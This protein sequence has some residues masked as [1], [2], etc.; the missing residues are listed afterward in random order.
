MSDLKQFLLDA[1][2]EYGI[3]L[4]DETAEKFLIYKDMLSDWNRRINLTAITDDEGIIIKH[5]IDSLLCWNSGVMHNNCRLIDIGT[6]AGFPG[7]ALKLAFPW[8]K[9]W[10]LDSVRKKLLFLEDVIKTLSLSDV[11][12]I[13]GRAE[14]YGKKASF[15]ES[16]DVVTARAVAALPVLAEYCL[17]FAKIGGHVLCMKGPEVQQELS[18]SEKAV[19]LLGGE[20]KDVLHLSLPASSGD[21]HIV[22]LNK[23]KPT[24]AAYPRKP[25]VPAKKP[26]I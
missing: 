1:A 4:D 12:L 6:G 20:V 7:L 16:F 2:K 18:A 14:D 26:I 8:L 25:G 15:R 24:P 17:P 9:V 3:V 21:R 19:Q 11:E 23:I 13:W 10:L 22:V 5:F